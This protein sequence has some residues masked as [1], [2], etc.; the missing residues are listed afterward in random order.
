MSG[1]PAAAQ[2]TQMSNHGLGQ[3]HRVRMRRPSMYPLVPVRMYQPATTW[4]S[5]A[6]I[7]TLADRNGR[8]LPDY[9]TR[10]CVML[11]ITMGWVV[12]CGLPF[13]PGS[14]VSAIAW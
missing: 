12:G 8:V 5:G 10:Y 1:R 14:I 6:P 3:D 13:G 7:G 4:G 11:P 2:S 9:P